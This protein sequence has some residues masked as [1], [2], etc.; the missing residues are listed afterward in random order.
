MCKS[1]PHLLISLVCLTFFVSCSQCPKVVTKVAGDAEF[2]QFE[3]IRFALP[4]AYE[5]VAG[6]TD[7]AE[8]LVQWRGPRGVVRLYMLPRPTDRKAFRKKF[9]NRIRS[10]YK[11]IATRTIPTTKDWRDQSVVGNQIEILL[12]DPNLALDVYYL[13]GEVNLYV[14]YFQRTMAKNGPIDPTFLPLEQLFWDSLCIQ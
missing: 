10:V 2:Y 5:I 13:E 8:G 6:Q 3:E 11:G 7:A 14:M 9:L 1:K 12:G 4:K